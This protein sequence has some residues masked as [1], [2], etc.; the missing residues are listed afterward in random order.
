M[1]NKNY[2]VDRREYLDFAEKIIQDEIKGGLVGRPD[3]VEVEREYITNHSY[4]HLKTIELISPKDK[5]RIL[6]IGT[7]HG[8]LEYFIKKKF[9]YDVETVDIKEEVSGYYGKRMK[10]LG[11]PQKACDLN[12][13]GLPYA[14]D[15]F[16]VV[17]FS[18]VLEHL[19]VSPLK[20]LLEI[21]RILKKGGYLIVVTP[22]VASFS[23]I[24]FLI[25]GRHFMPEYPMEMLTTMPDLK[26]TRE[27]TIRE[28]KS[29]LAQANFMIDTLY[30][31]RYQDRCWI[32][33]K[34]S[35]TK[36]TGMVLIR[37]IFRAIVSTVTLIFPRFRSTI[38]IR[39]RK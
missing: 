11:I 22:N 29:L 19:L 39:A 15:S 7:G 2:R 1:V 36:N 16:D 17:I 8:V 23:H 14:D 12:R 34:Y 28:M 31:S 5:L 25:C 30:M 4:R 26:H 33:R 18:E 21:H 27:Y 32:D 24:V 6:N 13:E 10:R 35:L 20:P 9:G 37:N 38:I 3:T